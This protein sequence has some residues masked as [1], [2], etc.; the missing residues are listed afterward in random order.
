MVGNIGQLTVMRENY[1][2]VTY[3]I[4]LHLKE[5]VSLVIYVHMAEEG[6]WL[7]FGNAV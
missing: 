2:V 3:T 7:H 4:P 1:K 6:A 5:I